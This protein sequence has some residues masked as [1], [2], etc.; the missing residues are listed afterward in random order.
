MMLGRSMTRNFMAIVVLGPAF[1]ATATAGSVHVGHPHGG[2]P[3]AHWG[4]PAGH[5]KFYEKMVARFNQNPKAFTNRHHLM[6]KAIRNPAFN[7][8]M[9]RRLLTHSNR[10]IR[11]HPCFSRFLDGEL[12]QILAASTPGPGPTPN[13]TLFGTAAQ[14]L[15][16]GGG[17]S[18]A[19][20]PTPSI[21]PVPEPSSLVLVAAAAVALG[22]AGCRRRRLHGPSVGRSRA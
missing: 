5:V 9:T 8:E 16:S 22:L 3:P 10:F 13:P 12:H 6:S 19:P 1:T 17:T 4:T 14:E 2:R 7:Q 15:T 20:T 18:P 11:N 21:R